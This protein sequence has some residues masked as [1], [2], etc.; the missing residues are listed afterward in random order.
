MPE[1]TG[2][3][4]D[5]DLALSQALAGVEGLHPGH[6]GLVALEQVGDA[7]QQ[8]PALPGA[9]V[10]PVALVEGGDVLEHP[11]PRALAYAS[12]LWHGVELGRA[13]T[14]GIDTAWGWAAHI[15]YLLL[16]CVGGCLLALHRFARKLSD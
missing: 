4:V 11:V 14:L 10:R 15:G 6:L 5:V 7:E 16:W 2:H 9:G 8:V 13:S 12:P 1:D 3:V